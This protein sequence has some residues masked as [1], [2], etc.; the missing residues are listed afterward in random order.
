L[1]ILITGG[2]GFIGS[3]LVKRL[4]KDNDIYVVDN[5]STGNINNIQ[6]YIDNNLIKFYKLDITSNRIKKFIKENEF[7]I[8]YNFACPASPK[9]Y[10]KHPISTLNSNIYGV[11]NILDSIV[12]SNTIMFQASTSEIYGAAL[13]NPQKEN[14]FGNVNPIGVRSCY[15]ESKRVAETMIFDYIRKYNI[16]VRVG[17]IFNT[18]GPLMDINDGRVIIN[19]IKQALNNENITIYGTGSQTRSFCYIDDTLNLILKITSQEKLNS[20]INIG[21]DEEYAI[22][23]V[24]KKIIKLTNSKSRIIFLD[25]MQ[26]DPIKRRPYLKLAKEKYNY[27][28]V[29]NLDDGLKETVNFVKNNKNIT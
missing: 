21:N 12:N 15:D 18:Y 17:R 25:K 28:P 8:I 9:Y 4:I 3:N 26:D 1:K 29:F 16:D 11:K 6:K 22:L 19:F 27:E 7:D 5:L 23:D 10:L 2:A 20:P 13:E 14:Y 24:A